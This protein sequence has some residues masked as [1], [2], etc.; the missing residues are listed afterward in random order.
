MEI[1]RV[2]REACN[3]SF[4]VSSSDCASFRFFFKGWVQDRK[5]GNDSLFQDYVVVGVEAKPICQTP[6]S[7]DRQA[8]HQQRSALK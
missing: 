5:S 2:V 6:V 3:P 4:T 7:D 8:P 1:L